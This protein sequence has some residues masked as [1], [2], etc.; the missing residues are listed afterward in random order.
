MTTKKL[1]VYEGKHW[2]W[3]STLEVSKNPL[4]FFEEKSEEFGDTFCTKFPIGKAILTSNPTLIQQVLQSNNRNYEKDRGYDELAWLLGRGLVTSRSELWKKQRRIAQP[5]FYKKSLE[6]LYRAMYEIA[7]KYQEELLT[8]VGEIVDISKEMMA[9]TAKIAMKA[10]FSENLEGDL[11]DIYNCIS[12]A[13]EYVIRRSFRPLLIPFLYINGQ[14][15]KFL[16]QRKV[17]D[18]LIYGIIEKRKASN[19]NYYDF[20]QMLLD[21]R[22]EDTGE[23]MSNEQ[24]RDELVTIFS[25][26]HE[27]S[28]NGLSWAI[29]LLCQHPEIVGKIREEATSILGG[30][31]PTFEQTKQLVYTRQ[32]IE[33]SMRMYSPVWSVSRY[34]LQED[35]WNGY[36]L[37]AKTIIIC[38]IY[39]LHKNPDLWKNPSVFDPDRF[40][41]ELVKNRSKYHFLPF[42]AGPRMCIGNQF[43]MMEMILLLPMLVQNFDF[44]LVPDHPV[45]LDPKVTLRPKYGIKVKVRKAGVLV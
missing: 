15:R 18:E 36:K 7:E 9:V 4:L 26:G 38:L 29:F 1:P 23:V 8:K 33:E 40:A 19:E 24:L 41:P 16:R 5:A 32:V 14:H 10:L 28:S 13:Q 17:M 6:E 35:E 45:E 25:A 34:A 39:H 30:K 42:G 37:E 20:L 43:A 12:V 44:E 21:A 31:L 22:Y 11:L 27:T 2:L 3:K